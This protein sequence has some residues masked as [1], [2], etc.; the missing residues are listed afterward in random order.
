[1]KKR[2]FKWLMFAFI[3][4][5]VG[6]VQGVQ[7]YEVIGLRGIS[8]ADD[9]YPI[10]INNQGEVV[11]RDDSYYPSS[12]FLINQE[13]AYVN[14]TPNNTLYAQARAINNQGVIG[15]QYDY[16]ATV[17][18]PTGNGNN[19]QICDLHSNILGMN[20]C[21]S[22]AGFVGINN[23]YL[24]ASFNVSGVNDYTILGG[25][26]QCQHAFARS[27]NNN[28]QIV[29]IG[30]NGGYVEESQD[31]YAILFDPT[32]NGNN[33][34]LGGVYGTYGSAWDINDSGIIVGES[35]VLEE[36]PLMRATIF[37]VNPEDTIDLGTTIDGIEHGHSAAMAINCSNQIVGAIGDGG[38]ARFATL[39]DSTG[40]GN[41]IDLNTLID[42]ESGWQL[43]TAYDIN[44][45]GWIIGHGE[46]EGIVQGYLLKPV[47]EPATL[48]LLLLG[49]VLT[50]RAQK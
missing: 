46:F 27:I 49:V 23:E 14:L 35:H 18:D 8:G 22:A 41:N 1:M 20:D 32:G 42:T 50:R 25:I 43:L 13:S 4:V 30:Y 29:G 9:P 33:L 45:D 34:H 36:D 3:C 24:G 2:R 40:Q 47:P 44:D 7:Q 6:T 16:Y 38:S 5:I 39:F 37:G 12:A 21:D 17:F 48:S 11:G 15:G 31:N 19:T 28:N 26:Q 10:A